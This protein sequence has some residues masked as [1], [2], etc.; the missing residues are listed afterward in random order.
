MKCEGGHCILRLI[1]AFDRSHTIYVFKSRGFNDVPLVLIADSR[2]FLAL[3]SIF[4]GMISS[5]THL[6]LSDTLGFDL[7]L[8]SI[9]SQTK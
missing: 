3:G 6:G 4:N 2:S 7:M 9:Q 8:V 5:W 1:V